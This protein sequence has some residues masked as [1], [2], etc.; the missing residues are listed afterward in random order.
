MSSQ[1]LR[2]PGAFSIETDGGKRLGLELEGDETVR[3]L[4]GPGAF[5]IEA[6]NGH[7]L[8]LALEEDETGI[9]LLVAAEE[10]RST[11]SIPETTKA[12]RRRA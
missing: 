7:R 8:E 11:L 6:G 9:V 4:K 10:S 2:G 1:I 12:S 3:V 5:S